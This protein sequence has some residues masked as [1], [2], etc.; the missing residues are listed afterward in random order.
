MHRDSLERILCMYYRRVFYICEILFGISTEHLVLC[1]AL[2][3]YV[4]VPKLHIYCN[5]VRYFRLLLGY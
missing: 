5:M 1:K 3:L 4:D 2:L